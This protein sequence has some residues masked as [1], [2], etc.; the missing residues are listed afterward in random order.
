MYNLEILMTD[1]KTIQNLLR[2]VDYTI[3]NRNFVFFCILFNYIKMHGAKH[4][5]QLTYLAASQI[6]VL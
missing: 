1:E 3:E 2:L 5:V 4:K 6:H